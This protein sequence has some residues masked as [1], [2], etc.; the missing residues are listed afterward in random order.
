MEQRGMNKKLDEIPLIDRSE[1]AQ[2]LTDLSRESRS[3]C[4][5][6]RQSVRLDRSSHSGS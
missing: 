2:F 6:E 4:E 5:V 3:T 1:H